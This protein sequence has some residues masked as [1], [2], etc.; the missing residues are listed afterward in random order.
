MTLAPGAAPAYSRSIQVCRRMPRPRPAATPRTAA[1]RRRP[2]QSRSQFTVDALFEA[3]L[4][5]L[6]E[7]GEEALT[8]NRIA[9]RAGVSIGTLYQYFPTR[10]AIV[11]AIVRRRRTAV[12]EQMDGL[13]GRVGRGELEPRTMLRSFIALLLRAER[14]GWPLPGASTRAAWCIRRARQRQVQRPG[15]RQPTPAQG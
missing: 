2:A 10:E 3:T 15:V 13:L 6:A 7:G 11:D 12:I 14:A 9:E 4:H 8:T 5:L 1:P